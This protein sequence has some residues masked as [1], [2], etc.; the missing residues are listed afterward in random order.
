[1]SNQD[2]DNWDD[3]YGLEKTVSVRKAVEIRREAA[4]SEL[5]RCAAASSDP[6][7]TAAYA[8]WVALE[9]MVSGCLVR[10]KEARHE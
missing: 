10:K 9:A 6:K 1:M 2:D 5:K 7:V 3:W 8:T 4:L